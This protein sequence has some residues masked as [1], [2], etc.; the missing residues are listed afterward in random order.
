VGRPSITSVGLTREKPAS[1]SISFNPL[2]FLSKVIVDDDGNLIVVKVE[3]PSNAEIGMTVS[4]SGNCNDVSELHSE[5]ARFP[6]V[7][8]EDGKL[9]EAKDEHP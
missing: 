2:T 1:I 6:I 9:T 5:K 3:H 4:F 7:V 8:M